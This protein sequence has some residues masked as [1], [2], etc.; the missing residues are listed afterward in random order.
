M[1]RRTVLDALNA[2]S[3]TSTAPWPTAVATDR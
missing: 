1:L 2:F 3:L